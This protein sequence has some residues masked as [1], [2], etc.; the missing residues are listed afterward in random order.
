MEEVAIIADSSGSG[1]KLAEG[2]F[3]YAKA[4]EGR[5]FSV[6]LIDVNSTDFKDGEFKVKIADNIRRKK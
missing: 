1:Y 4:K 5:S 2:I 6:Q 3:E